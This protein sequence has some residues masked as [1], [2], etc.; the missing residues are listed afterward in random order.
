MHETSSSNVIIHSLNHF[1]VNDR[2]LSHRHI[3]PRTIK[4]RP[5]MRLRHRGKLD[6]TFRASRNTPDDCS[7]AICSG[8]SKT[9]WTMEHQQMARIQ[10]TL[11][12]ME[13]RCCV[14]AWAATGQWILEGRGHG[15]RKAYILKM[16]DCKRECVIWE[17]REGRVSK[18]SSGFT[19]SSKRLATRAWRL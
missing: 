7:R 12:I 3:E 11:R 5:K 13:R 9:W 2:M 17:T 16:R 4:V 15:R 19:Q 1:C 18:T 10:K 14:G 6:K 8:V